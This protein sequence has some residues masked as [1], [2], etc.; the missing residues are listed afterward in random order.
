[1]DKIFST[2]VNEAVIQR[3]G[4]LAKQLH[5]SKKTVIERAIAAYSEKIEKEV[6]IEVLE[7]TFGAWKREEPPEETIEKAKTAFR[8]SLQRRNTVMHKQL[9]EHCW[10]TVRS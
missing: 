3:I 10:V 5:T 7:E 9:S 4:L 8:E 6:N 1:M 2:R